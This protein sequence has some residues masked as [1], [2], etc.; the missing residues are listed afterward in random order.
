M[1][2]APDGDYEVVK[3]TCRTHCQSQTDLKSFF[4]LK[5][6]QLFSYSCICLS[7]APGDSGMLSHTVYDTGLVECEAYKEQAMQIFTQHQGLAQFFTVSRQELPTS[8]SSRE[9]V[10]TNICNYERVGNVLTG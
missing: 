7:V 8:Y 9:G 1:I 2:G 5:R 10:V 3:A 4:G 6:K